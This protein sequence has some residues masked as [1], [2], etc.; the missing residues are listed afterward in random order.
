MKML[1]RLE[2]PI[3]AK[4]FHTDQANRPDQP[5]G[6]LP[7][8]RLNPAIRMQAPCMIIPHHAQHLPIALRHTLQLVLLLDGVRVAASLGSVD[9]LFGQALGDALDVAERG[10]AGADGE[11]RDGLVDAAERRHIDGLATDG[12]GGSDTGGV[13]AGSAVDDGVDSD[14]DGVLIGHDVDLLLSAIHHVWSPRT[15]IYSSLAATRKFVTYD[16]ESVGNNSN[17]HELLAVVAAVHHERVGEALNDGALGLPESLDG[18]AAG[19][20]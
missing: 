9:E 1:I 16:L 8:V 3:H 2:D 7:A 13:F 19:R 12:T 4:A 10:L 14:L 20:V 11:E 6:E 17:S 18:I 5:H 15:F